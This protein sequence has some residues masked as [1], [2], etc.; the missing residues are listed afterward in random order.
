MTTPPAVYAQFG[1]ALAF[2]ERTLTGILREHLAERGTTPETW[3]ALKLVAAGGPGLARDTLVGKL[4]G[5]RDLDTAAVAGLLARLEADGLLG[6][7][8]HVHLTAAGAAL[9]Q[10]LRE[11]VLAATERLL[12]Q[13]DVADIETTLRTMLAVTER[14]AVAS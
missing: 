10:S 6:G 14:A 4:A 9:F 7:D 13:F 2:A 12:S 1:Q 11:H 8:T 5:S 3:Y